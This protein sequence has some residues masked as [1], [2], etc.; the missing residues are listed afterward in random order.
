M[1]NLYQETNI[2]GTEY[3]RAKRVEIENQR[4]VT[5]I[6]NFVEELVTVLDNGRSMSVD[7]GNLSST[8]DPAD[9]IELLDPETGEMTGGTMTQGQ[10][11]QALYSFYMKLATERDNRVDVD[12]MNFGM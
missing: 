12:P 4:A 5:P 1:S 11:F 3:R 7:V 6:I 2:T 10:V 8:F 9:I